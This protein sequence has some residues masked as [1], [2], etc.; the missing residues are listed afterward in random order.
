MQI[1]ADFCTFGS[2]FE[3]IRSNNSKMMTHFFA[4][5]VFL[6]VVIE[7]GNVGGAATA[8]NIH[9]NSIINV[10]KYV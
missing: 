7:M 6:V 9:E 3:N 5:N 8:G 10:F 1:C 2:T 4:V